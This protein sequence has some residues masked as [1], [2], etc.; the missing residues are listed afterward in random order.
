[1]KKKSIS[2]PLKTGFFTYDDYEKYK[3]VFKIYNY[4]KFILV[5]PLI[6]L[7]L[8]T[9]PFLKIKLGWINTKTIGNFATAFEIFNHENKYKKN[10]IILWFTDNLVANKFWVKKIT[11]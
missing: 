6:V 8:I 7:H 11:Q 10:E 1:M 5:S 4:I 9:Y 3:F 2:A